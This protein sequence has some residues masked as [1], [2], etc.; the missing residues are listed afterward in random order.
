MIQLTYITL[1]YI[2]MWRTI[3]ITVCVTVLLFC[4]LNM[5]NHGFSRLASLTNYIYKGWCHVVL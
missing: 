1:T 3:E 4:H 5:E 2:C